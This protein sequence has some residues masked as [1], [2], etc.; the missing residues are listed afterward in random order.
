MK[1]FTLIIA[2]GLVLA[3]CGGGA[4][5]T[6]TVADVGDTTTTTLADAG[7]TTTTAGGTETTTT[8]SAA[9]NGGA[10]DS[11]L[12]G[13]WTLEGQPFFDAI[14]DQM[15]PEDLQGATFDYVGGDYQA[16]VGGDG[17]FIDRR[18]DWNFAVT[19]PAG[20]LEII[21]NHERTGEWYA[22]D[23]VMYV[24]L[25]GGEPADQ[26]I[27]I[28]GEPFEFPGGTPPFSTPAMEWTPADYDCDGDTLTIT[29]EGVETVWKRS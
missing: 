21:V 16:V 17:S 23:G 27:F 24:T 19:S 10:D 12:E 9:S 1:R 8:L 6:T 5:T 11:C 7:D 28:D 3:A 15:S 4:E 18:V 22:E 29:A 20:D 13:T 26:Q 14:M 25:P 2:L